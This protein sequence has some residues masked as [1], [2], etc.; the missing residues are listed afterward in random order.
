M[1]VAFACLETLRLLCVPTADGPPNGDA[2]VEGCPKPGKQKQEDLQETLHCQATNKEPL[3][4]QAAPVVFP[5][6]S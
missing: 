5:F 4:V 1:S 2:G 3:L 6:D